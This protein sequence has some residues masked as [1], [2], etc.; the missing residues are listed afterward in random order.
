MSTRVNR[1]DVILDV[2]SN[3][4]IEQGYATTSV[5]QIAEAAGMTEAALYYHF[6]DGKRA[7]LQ[8]V[9]EQYAPDMIGVLDGCRDAGSLHDL[10]SQFGRAMVDLGRRKLQKFHWINREYS[11]LTEDECEFIHHKQVMLH[12]GLTDLVRQFVPDAERASHIAWMLIVMAFGYGQLFLV[13][14]LG[15]V[16]E[17]NEDV[18]LEVLADTIAYGAS[19]DSPSSPA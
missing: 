17:L 13:Q 2:A 12:D 6:K 14:R 8:A 9:I 19:A 16:G 4:F 11:R 3:L 10:V 15:T 1:R 18:L 7:L 5:R